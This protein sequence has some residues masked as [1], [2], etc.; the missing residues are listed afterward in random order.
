MILQALNHLYERLAADP[1]ADVAEYGFSVQKASFCVVIAP[2]TTSFEVQSLLRQEDKN[3]LPAR[4]FVPGTGARSG[5]KAPPSFLWDN[6]AYVF[7]ISPKGKSDNW[8]KQRFEAFRDFHVSLL[9]EIRSPAYEAF[10][11]FLNYLT[12]ND[13]RVDTNKL[14]TYFG[15]FRLR[16]EQ[17]YI[18]EES[19]I[20]KWWK[21]RWLEQELSKSSTQST[22]LVSGKLEPI[23]ESHFPKIK[24]VKDKPGKP[25]EKYLVAVDK[26][27]R[28]AESYG[29]RCNY[30]SPVSQRAAFQYTTALNRLLDPA[31]GRRFSIGDTSVVCWTAEP[32]P[33]E[34]WVVE[35]FNPSPRAEDE[36]ELGKV[37]SVLDAI[38]K[39]KYPTEFGPPDTPF[40]ILGLAPNAARI[41]VRFWHVSTVGQFVENLRKHFADLEICRGPQ[42][43]PYPPLWRLLRET[44]RDAKDIPDVME[45]AVARALLT[46]GPYPQM[47]YTALLRRIRADRE[48]RYVRAAALKACLIRIYEQE[49][50]MSL[51]EERSDPAYQ[52]G[53]LFAELEKTQEDA[54]PGI[55]DTIKDRY[56][57]AASSTPAT[58][59]PRLIR[60]NQHHLGKLEKGK[61]VYH[62]RRI[63]QIADML[64]SFPA[65]FSLQE[66]GLFAIGYYHQRQSLFTKKSQDASAE[67]SE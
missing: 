51:D 50:P 22:C 11:S 26:Q 10:C 30:N 18:H 58:V 25:S 36:T 15:V 38:S 63:Q 31:M 44:V 7:G 29:K 46:G 64:D 23:A 16:G 8:A 60:M 32:S 35:M 34:D 37:K 39:G 1:T 53:R 52:L 28:S 9:N 45:G 41:S 27:F 13:S 4:V 5:S 61:R 65:H 62:E 17:Q 24:G 33:A 2:D 6:P 54:L 19:T 49:I 40:Y 57:G 42:D 48:V 59:F 3:E 67:V 47:F 56:F 20:K 55:N 12:P 66:Q 43:L 14:G 21:D